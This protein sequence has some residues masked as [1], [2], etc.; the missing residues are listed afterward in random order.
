VVPDSFFDWVQNGY[1]HVKAL[2]VTDGTMVQLS[3]SS[4]WTQNGNVTLD[5]R[6]SYGFGTRNLQAPLGRYER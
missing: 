2:W 6:Q 3:T 1:L 5:V 4:T